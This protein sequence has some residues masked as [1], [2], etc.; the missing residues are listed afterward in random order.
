[1]ANPLSNLPQRLLG[2]TKAIVKLMIRRARQLI[3]NSRGRYHGLSNE[4]VISYQAV[5]SPLTQI[6]LH[7]RQIVNSMD[8]LP[9]KYSLSGSDFMQGPHVDFAKQ[10]VQRGDDPSWDYTQTTYYQLALQGRLPFPI[11]GEC[12]ARMRCQKF[13]WMIEQLRRHG[14]QPKTFGA[15]VVVPTT[16]GNWMVINGKH[17]MA[18]MIALGHTNIDVFIG[19]DNEV[20][21]QFKQLAESVWPRSTY[22]RSFEA[23]ESL[24]KV[25]REKAGE[26]Q[27]LIQQIKQA[28]LETWAN[29]YHPLPFYEF[30]NLTTQVSPDTSYKR[31]QMILDAADGDVVD[32]RVLDLGC[33][34]GF[35]SFSL[36]N[37]GA[38]V[39][40]VELRSDYHDISKRI[41]ELYD[42][43]V[44]FRND[45]LTPE[46]VNEV[47]DVDITLCFSMIQ[48]VIDQQGMDYGKQILKTISERS[49]LL[50]FDVSVNHGAACLLCPGGQEL[51]YVYDFLADA[52][53]YTDI[54]CIG[55]V[56]PYG[57]DTRYVF[58]CKHA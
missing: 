29:I 18:A 1:M 3:Q 5:T 17:R 11:I 34:L 50:L 44:R 6:N 13:I 25:N 47:G 7:G 26:I 42:M 56:H 28:K 32:K 16:E 8:F 35:Y 45:S 24:G 2:K 39:T 19:F 55:Q 41:V 15:I 52:T 4:D 22:S 30:G 12:Q 53:T 21:A 49:R 9:D 51:V 48:W 54:Q 33:N 38:K 10:Y 40:S 46:L 31:L 20:R 14:Y 43:N 57:N 37:R 36:A 27:E 58:A 23:M